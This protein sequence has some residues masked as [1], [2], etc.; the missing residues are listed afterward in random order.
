[1]IPV[2]PE[3]VVAELGVDAGRGGAAADHRISIGL[4]QGRAG[5]PRPRVRNSGPLG[6]AARRD[7]G[8]RGERALDGG[9]QGN[10]VPDEDLARVSPLMRNH[11]TPNGSYFQSPRSQAAEMPE[12]NLA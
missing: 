3:T 1:M 12:P 7:R 6:S 9:C 10:I 8:P 5:V 11:I 2:A 4:G